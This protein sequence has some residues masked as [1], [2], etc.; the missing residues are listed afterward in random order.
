MPRDWF[1]ADVK[2]LVSDSILEDIARF[3]ERSASLTE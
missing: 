1:E 2:E 3:W